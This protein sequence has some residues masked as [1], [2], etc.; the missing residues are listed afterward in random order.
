MIPQAA[1]V[2]LADPESH[3]VPRVVLSAAF[4]HDQSKASVGLAGW[5]PDGLLHVEVADYRPGTSWAVPAA[6][7]DERAA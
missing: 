6:D 5:R 7:R 1:W 2:D 3:P 4:A